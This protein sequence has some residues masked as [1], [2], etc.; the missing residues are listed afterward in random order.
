M[1][2]PEKPVPHPTELSQPYWDAAAEG[3]LVIQRCAEI[4]RA[5]I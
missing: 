5:H 2:M 1:T 3:R 4:G